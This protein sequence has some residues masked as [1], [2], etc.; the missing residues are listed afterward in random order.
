MYP[1][2]H[3][4]TNMYTTPINTCMYYAM[5]VDYVVIIYYTGINQWH[6]LALAEPSINN[7]LIEGSGHWP[8]PQ[9]LLNIM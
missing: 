1:C 8:L 2:V 3:I 7:K 5:Y 4:C 6:Y 9:A